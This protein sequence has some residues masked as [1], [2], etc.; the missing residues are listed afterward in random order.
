MGVKISLFSESTSLMVI[1]LFRFGKTNL[2][3]WDDHGKEV[4]QNNSS[5]GLVVLG[6]SYYTWPKIS[7]GGVV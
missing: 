5:K 3:T 2:G 7:R 1:D 4:V 6:K